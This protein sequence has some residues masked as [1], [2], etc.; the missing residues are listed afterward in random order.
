MRYFKAI[1][2]M[3][4]KIIL[5]ISIALSFAC[6]AQNR[7]KIIPYLIGIEAENEIYQ[8][9]KGAKNDSVAFYME[10]LPNE[11]YKIHFIREGIQ[12]PNAVSNRMLF[13]NDRFYP[14]ILESD[15]TFYVKMENQIPTIRKFE[16]EDEK[17]LLY[18]KIPTINERMKDKN[19]IVKD[20]RIPLYELTVNWIIDNNGNLVSSNKRN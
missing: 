7:D 9:M 14:L 16:N 3:K 11:Q 4:R 10:S 15:Y 1:E 20:K 18:I 12:T 5:I 6:K 17:K 2:N 8:F 13:I 19:L